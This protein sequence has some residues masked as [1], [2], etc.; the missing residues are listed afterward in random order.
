M[1]AGELKEILNQLDS[2]TLAEMRPSFRAVIQICQEEMA[3]NDQMTRANEEMSL[4]FQAIKA[5]RDSLQRQTDALNKKIG[6]LQDQLQLRKNDIFGRSTENTDAVINSTASQASPEDP[7]DEDNKEEEEEVRK[8]EARARRFHPVYTAKE[9]KHGKRLK[10]QRKKDFSGLPEKISYVY[11]EEELNRE[12]GRYNWSIKGWTDNKVVEN[13]PAVKIVHIY[14]TPIISVGLEGRLVRVPF[15]RKTLKNSFVSSSL[16]ASVIYNKFVLGIP[17]NRQEK[18]LA[19][20]GITLRRSTMSNWVIR[21]S[22]EYFLPIVSYMGELLKKQEYNQCDETVLQVINDGRG[23]N[24]KS[25]MWVHTSSELLKDH[26]IS[27]FCYEPT[28]STEHLRKFY[29]SDIDYILT[30]TSDSFAAYFTYESEN[31]NV[32]VSSCMMHC[33]RRFVEA[34]RVLIRSGKSMEEI[35]DTPE[36]KAILMIRD[37]YIEE[38]PLKSLTPEERRMRRQEDVKPKVDAFFGY[39]ETLDEN[40]PSFSQYM[41]DAIRYAKKYRERLCAFLSDP[42][43]PIDNGNSE[44]KFK[45]LCQGRRNWLFCYSPDGADACANIYSLVETAKSNGASVEYYLQY[46]LEKMPE[47]MNRKASDQSWLPSMMPWSDEYRAYEAARK[48]EMF[49]TYNQETP[50]EPP[51][52][53]RRKDAKVKANAVNRLIRL[54]SSL[55]ICANQ[56]Q[57]VHG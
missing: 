15:E 38:T 27:V 21:F 34:L 17:L 31:S 10:G 42:N 50:P 33:R 6:E 7:L 51:R 45:C 47:M 11:D 46:L 19:A 25:Y 37:F 28:R 4:Q 55:M 30:I 14:K 8:N 24:T 2:M 44:R 52:T 43:I 18:D 54:A 29:G 13:I 1:K 16:A 32:T 40:D 3:R 49:D 39:I 23:P 22:Q 20:H 26:P 41:T 12:Y 56:L 5:E 57:Q 35:L 48:K 36:A 9:K 53:P